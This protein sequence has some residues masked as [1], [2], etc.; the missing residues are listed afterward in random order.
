[1]DRNN[2]VGLMLL[3]EVAL[4]DMNG[5]KKATVSFK[6]LGESKTNF[7]YWLLSLHFIYHAMLFFFG[8]YR[9]LLK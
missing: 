3:S 5:L 9:I 8:S 4:G 7:S 2:P 6:Y 1:V